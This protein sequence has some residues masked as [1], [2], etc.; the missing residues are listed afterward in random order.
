[1]ANSSEIIKL[2]VLIVGGIVIAVGGQILI[3]KHRAAK[4]AKGDLDFEL[5]Y[6]QSQ[7]SDSSENEAKAQTYIS[8]YKVQYP[9]ESIKQGLLNMGI[10]DSEAEIYL[11]KYM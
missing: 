10:E 9:R 8:Q 2:I 11:S 4:K 3:N 5:S 1:M 6:N 7:G